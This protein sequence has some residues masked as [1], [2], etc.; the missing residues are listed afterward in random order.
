MQVQRSGLMIVALLISESAFAGFSGINEGVDVAWIAIAAALVFLMQAGF[1]LLE[2][3]MSRAKNA[4]NVIM[5]NWSDMCVGVLVFWAVGFGL[6]LGDNPSGWFGTS[7][8]A[9][10]TGDGGD[11]V[12]LLYQAMFA[13]TAATIVSGAVAERMRYGAYVVASIAITACV[14][15]LFGAWAWGSVTTGQGW[16][17]A[18]GFHDFAGATVVHSVGGWLALAGVVVLGPRRGRFGRDGEVRPVPGHN[19][20]LV[21][22]G[23]FIL[24]FGWYGFNGGS[25]LAATPEIGGILLV[26]QLGGAS[27]VV[28]ALLT[29]V[30]L[31]QKV[32]MTLAVNGAIG[33]LVAVTAGADVLSPS[34]AIVTGLIG[35]FVVVLGSFALLALRVDDVVGAVP[36]HAFAGAWG[37]IAVALFRSDQRF[38]PAGVLVQMLG[39]GAAFVWA[40][41]AGLV[42]FSLV[43]VTI[44]L[45]SDSVHEQRGLDYTEHNETA[46]PE[47]QQQL[48]NAG[49][50]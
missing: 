26:T 27:G 40:F 5:K 9:L 2:A 6:M 1:A 25:T 13:A 46:Y 18:L 14:Y 29:M 42:V 47:F 15:P 19:L 32:L 24:W 7:L 31:R 8:F 10:D 34:M 17:A 4:I 30:L 41:L 35:G 33:G 12:F 16:L 49:Q 43:R 38:D 23:G 11:A 37:T 21:A 20:T 44:G 22:L 45:R 50:S 48:T 36:A 28:G 39:V 3:G